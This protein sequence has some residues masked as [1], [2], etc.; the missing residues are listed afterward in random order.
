[1]TNSMTLNQVKA[2]LVRYLNIQYPSYNLTEDSLRLWKSNMSYYTPEKM[3][4][5]LR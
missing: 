2:K 1:M 5:Y 3:A 4:D